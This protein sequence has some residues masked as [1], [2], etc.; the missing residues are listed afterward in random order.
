MI[1]IY[2]YIYSI[3]IYSGLTRKNG[4]TQINKVIKVYAQLNV[5][6]NI[7]N[8]LIYVHSIRISINTIIVQA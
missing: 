8:K 2:I 5:I 3:M 7:Y 1:Y 4:I 6:V